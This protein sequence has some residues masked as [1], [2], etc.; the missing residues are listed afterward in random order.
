LYVKAYIVAVLTCC[1]A[2]AAHAQILCS[3]DRQLGTRERLTVDLRLKSGFENRRANAMD[4]AAVLARGGRIVHAFP[5]ALLRVQVDTTGLRAL[6]GARTGI[7][8]VAFVVRDTT[9]FDVPVQIHLDRPTASGDSATLERIGGKTE[10]FRSG[11]K[12]PLQATVPE[13]LLS[14]IP[15]L[16]AGV[17]SVRAQAWGCVVA[18]GGSPL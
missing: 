17:K 15:T 14:R 7:A 1:V 18:G 6:L 5:V 13:S 16:F 12:R 3:M 11:M 2:T 4:S 8:D 9:K 10:M